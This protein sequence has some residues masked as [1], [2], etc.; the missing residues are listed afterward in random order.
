MI[1]ITKLTT[2]DLVGSP[3]FNEAKFYNYS[4]YI[5][6]IKR[7]ERKKKLNKIWQNLK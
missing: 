5:R 4:E 6:K 2:Y 1:Q 3:G 7:E